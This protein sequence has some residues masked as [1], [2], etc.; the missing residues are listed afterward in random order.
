MVLTKE[1]PG[2]P[3]AIPATTPAVQQGGYTIQVASVQS[4]KAAKGLSEILLKKG[5]SSYTKQ[6][7]KYVI[8]LAG[9]FAKKEDAQTSLRE[10]K[11]SYADCFIK[12]I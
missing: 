11:K 3:A 2:V 10:L 8:V 1:Q 7:G 5:F 4:E 9:N 6:S 12:K